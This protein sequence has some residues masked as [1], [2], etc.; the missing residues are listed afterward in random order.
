MCHRLSLLYLPTKTK[1]D[2]LTP[3]SPLPSRRRNLRNLTSPRS[4]RPRK[5]NSSSMAC[6]T[7]SKRCTRVYL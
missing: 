3:N 5:T 2:P 7:R 6:G 4:R 1:N